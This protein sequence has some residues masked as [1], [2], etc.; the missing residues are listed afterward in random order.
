MSEQDIPSVW[1]QFKKLSEPACKVKEL[2]LG[3]MKLCDKDVIV[4]VKNLGQI[5]LILGS[6]SLLRALYLLVLLL[7]HTI[8]SSLTFQRKM[9]L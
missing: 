8:T 1:A 5:L 9:D 3:S 6:F 7:T 2:M 4:L